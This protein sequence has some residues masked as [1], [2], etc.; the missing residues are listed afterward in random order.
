MLV[1]AAADQR[2]LESLEDATAQ[3]LAWVSIMERREELNLDARQTR[4]AKNSQENADQTVLLRLAEAY[5][6]SIDPIQ[7]DPSDPTISFDI[8]NL[9]TS[10]SVAERVSRRLVE[11][12]A[13]LQSQFPAVILRS[14]LDTELASRWHDGHVT[15]STLWEDFAKYVYL[16][17]LKDLSVLIATVEK[18]PLSVTWISDGFAT[19][20]GIDDTGSYLGLVGGADPG[21][22][23]ASGLVVRPDIAQPILEATTDSADDTS[24]DT[25][26]DDTDDTDPISPSV[27]REFRGTVS[28]DST[29]PARDFGQISEEV[30]THLVSQ[31]NTD[32]EITVT[33]R[34]KKAD[35]FDDK[36]I[37][38]VT[39]NARTL[40]FDD[41]SGFTEG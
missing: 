11:K 28:L 32:I 36:T 40:K 4:Q 38:D 8:T 16:P 9:D 15:I 1:F 5:K 33:I 17:R 3:Y 34:A 22:L 31:V 27:T 29:R 6:Y 21:S 2:A 20:V 37:R 30:L 41:G 23:A 12:S 39:E 10:G 35:G 19:A 18:G 13:T 14:K 7:T 24:T 25:D 26:G